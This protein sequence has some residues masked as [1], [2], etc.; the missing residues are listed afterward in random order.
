[1]MCPCTGVTCCPALLPLS[2][3][4]APWDHARP[5]TDSGPRQEVARLFQAGSCEPGER[6]SCVFL[7]GDYFFNGKKT[8]LWILN[9]GC[10]IELSG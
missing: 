2:F 3:A 6:A 10:L 1:M 9:P 5:V 7:R 4:P 8:R